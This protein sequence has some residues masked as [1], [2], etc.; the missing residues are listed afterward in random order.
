MSLS[1]SVWRLNTFLV[2]VTH[3]RVG[4]GYMA[5]DVQYADGKILFNQVA[6][7]NAEFDQQTNAVEGPS[8]VHNNLLTLNRYII[9]SFLASPELLIDLNGLSQTAFEIGLAALEAGFRVKR[10]LKAL[11]NTPHY[12]FVDIGANYTSQEAQSLLAQRFPS[13]IVSANYDY[14]V[15]LEDNLT[16]NTSKALALQ[17]WRTGRSIDPNCAELHHLQKEIGNQEYVKV[18]NF[19]GYSRAYELQEQGFR[20]QDIVIVMLDTGVDDYDDFDCVKT[21]YQEKHGTHIRNIIRAFAPESTLV[22]REIFNATGNDSSETY[23]TTV[24]ILEALAEIE[25][26]YLQTGRKV[27]INMSFSGPKHPSLGPDLNLWHKLD[28]LAKH[29]PQQVLLVAS[30]GNHGDNLDESIAREIYY[31]SGAVKSFEEFNLDPLPNLISVASAGL[32]AVTNSGI[33]NVLPYN[34]TF[35][36]KHDAISILGYGINL[37]ILDDEERCISNSPDSAL[38]GSSFATASVSGMAALLWQ[39]H[40]DLS[41]EALIGLLEQKARPTDSAFGLASA[42]LGCATLQALGQGYGDTPKASLTLDASG[43]CYVAVTLSDEATQNED[44]ILRKYDI[45]GNLLWEQRQASDDAEALVDMSL[46]H[47]GGL[48][49]VG[50]VYDA[51][52][53]NQDAVIYKYDEAGRLLWQDMIDFNQRTEEASGIAIAP[54]GQVY[55]VGSSSPSFLRNTASSAFIIAYDPQGKRLWNQTISGANQSI[56]KAL[57]LTTSEQGVYLAGHTN[58]TLS[59]SPRLLHDVDSFIQ[60]YDEHGQLLWSKQDNMQDNRLAFD[61]GIALAYRANQLYLVVHAID[62]HEAHASY[63]RIY[64][65]QGNLVLDPKKLAAIEIPQSLAIFEGLLY[66]FGTHEDRAFIGS[67]V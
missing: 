3:L 53:Q 66:I 2:K 49:S 55:V 16:E 24:G 60:A 9:Q 29:Y 8:F 13:T 7:K 33:T 27:I 64:D 51:A 36:P 61:E 39:K 43:N 48:Y 59:G 26:A 1:M 30:A 58:S 11:D 57:A 35:S 18:D 37:C 54:S 17:G 12:A 63:L 47:Q 32:K 19:L 40:A 45:Q 28:E 4:Y 44:A 6:D 65:L 56:S 67:I 52:R 14:H 21:G 5:S 10:Y 20:G 15:P 31:P 46:D 41:P 25:Q 62:A 42:G 22:S 34:A 50:Y 23:L 38:I